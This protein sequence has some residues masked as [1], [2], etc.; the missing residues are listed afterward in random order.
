MPVHFAGFCA[1]MK[2]IVELS[3]KYSFK[4]IEDAAH[5]LESISNIEKLETIIT[6]LHSFMQIRT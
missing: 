2:N 5:A 1:D 6:V 3:E 4:I